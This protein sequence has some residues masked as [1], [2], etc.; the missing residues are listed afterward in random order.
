MC[1]IYWRYFFRRN[2]IN[3]NNLYCLKE[4]IIKICIITQKQCIFHTC[5]KDLSH[6]SNFSKFIQIDPVSV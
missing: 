1:E 4:C 5:E 3:C 2:V 6:F